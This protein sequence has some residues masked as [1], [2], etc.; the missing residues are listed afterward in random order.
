MA[1]SMTVLS[2]LIDSTLNG[3]DVLSFLHI[4]VVSPSGYK[5]LHAFLRRA[6]KLLSFCH[7]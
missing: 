3:K 7:P 5:H 4:L 1:Q 6:Q 2:A